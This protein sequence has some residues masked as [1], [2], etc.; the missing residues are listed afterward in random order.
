MADEA[1][2]EEREKTKATD[3]LAQVFRISGD[4]VSVRLLV[5]QVSSAET[6]TTSLVCVCSMM[7]RPPANV[8]WLLRDSPARNCE[9]QD[10]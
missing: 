9:E 4:L 8:R 2:E 3:A 7:P 6:I 5:S 10:I 1:F